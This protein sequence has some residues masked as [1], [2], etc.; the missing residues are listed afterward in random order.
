LFLCQKN[1]IS[2][3]QGGMV[4]A[5]LTSSEIQEI[6]NA[7]PE[8]LSEERY[9]IV[10]LALEAVGKIPYYW[11]GNANYPGYDGNNFGSTVAADVKGRTLK[12]LDCGGFLGWLYWT[13]GESSD[14]ATY[15]A[16]GFARAGTDATLSDAGVQPGDL[17]SYSTGDTSNGGSGNHCGLIVG[18]ND[19][20]TLQI[21]H[22]PGMPYNTVLYETTTWKYSDST[23]SIRSIIKD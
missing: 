13:V 10:K 18:V 9:E 4:S 2:L 20:G 21:V 22:T 1:G 6:L 17:F 11:G 8:D 19:D 16:A 3:S 12:G 5:E 15:S 14:Y 23:R 7:L